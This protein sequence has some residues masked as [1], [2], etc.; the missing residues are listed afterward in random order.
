MAKR[1]NHE[2][3]NR[4]EQARKAETDRD[5]DKRLDARTDRWLK[6]HDEPKP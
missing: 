3:A 4:Q 5:R 1:I 6:R 2:H